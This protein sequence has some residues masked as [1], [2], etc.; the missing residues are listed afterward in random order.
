MEV[1]SQ[2][3]RMENL[4]DEFVSVESNMIDVNSKMTRLLALT[5]HCYLW[6]I[7][8]GEIVILILCY[9]TF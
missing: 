3:V 6:L 7:I 5:N 9:V 8:T 1:K 4:D 2:N